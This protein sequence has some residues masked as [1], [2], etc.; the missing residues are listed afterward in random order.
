MTC[1]A[2]QSATQYRHSGLY[3]LD[4]LECCARLV[5]SAYPSKPHA[6]AMLAAIE[7][8]PSSPSRERVLKRVSERMEQDKP[9]EK[10]RLE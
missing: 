2:C 8:F 4:C 10:E 3:H 6:S 5:L 7:R 9:A 1:A